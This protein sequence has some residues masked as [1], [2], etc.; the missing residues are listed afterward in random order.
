MLGL[1]NQLYTSI[2]SLKQKSAASVYLNRLM[3]DSPNGTCVLR[4]LIP[5]IEYRNGHM[6]GEEFWLQPSFDVL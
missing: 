1:T 6:T 5:V 3:S 4:A 2:C